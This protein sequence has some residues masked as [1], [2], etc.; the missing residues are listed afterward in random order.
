MS[1]HHQFTNKYYTYRS[2]QTGTWRIRI[3]RN[4]EEPGIKYYDE[5]PEEYGF[6]IPTIQKINRVMCEQYSWRDYLANSSCLCCWIPWH[7]S[8]SSQESAFKQSDA[9][10]SEENSKSLKNKWTL[11]SDT[12]GLFLEFE[13][14]D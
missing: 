8:K 4:F 14:L 1:Q 12:A 5:L 9:I 13:Y 11:L 6:M 2:P 3:E 7:L 10:L